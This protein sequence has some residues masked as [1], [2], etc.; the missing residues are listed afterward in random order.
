[1]GLHRKAV[2][3][4]IA[5]LSLVCLTPVLGGCHKDEDASGP[6]YYNGKDFKGHGATSPAPAAGDAPATGTAPAMGRKGG[7]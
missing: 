3:A 2:S 7:E 6:G 4:L 5:L 1:M